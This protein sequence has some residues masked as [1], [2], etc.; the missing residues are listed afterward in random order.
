[1]KRYF[2]RDIS[3]R[4]ISFHFAR[5][6]F[7]KYILSSTHDNIFKKYILGFEKIFSEKIFLNIFSPKDIFLRYYRK[8]ISS[9]F[10][11]EDIYPHDNI[12]SSPVSNSRIAHGQK[13]QLFLI[14]SYYVIAEPSN[15]SERNKVTY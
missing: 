13:K 5:K 4:K 2:F 7:K 10:S 12:L 11:R 3:C 15:F 14:T 8:K 1:M 6:Y 9:H